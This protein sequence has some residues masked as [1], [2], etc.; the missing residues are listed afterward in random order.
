MTNKQVSGVKISNVM[1]QDIHGSSAT[2]VAVKLDCSPNNPC[3]GI[4]LE[5]VDLTFENKQAE[6]SCNHAG[7]ATSGV[8]HP[9]NCF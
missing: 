8:V 4:S 1:Y 3:T 2:E 5:D 7:G 9:N 6:A